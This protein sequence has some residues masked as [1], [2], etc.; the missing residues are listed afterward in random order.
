MVAELFINEQHGS[1]KENDKKNCLY[2]FYTGNY[3]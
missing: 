1:K 3:K 2:I